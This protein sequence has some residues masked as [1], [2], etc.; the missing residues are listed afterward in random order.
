[1]WTSARVRCASASAWI[2]ELTR[3]TWH[4]AERLPHR[5][6][7]N[8]KRRKS[9]PFVAYDR[10]CRR[11]VRLSCALVVLQQTG[12]NSTQTLLIVNTREQNV[13]RQRG[14]STHVQP[15]IK[16]LNY[17][18]SIASSIWTFDC[19]WDLAAWG[20][21]GNRFK[22]HCSTR[23]PRAR[24]STP[25]RTTRRRSTATV[26]T[27]TQWQSKL[28]PQPHRSA[29]HRTD[30]RRRPFSYRKH[31][32]VPEHEHRRVPQ[33]VLRLLHIFFCASSYRFKSMSFFT[34]FT[35]EQ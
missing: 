15:L 16:P 10:R 2:V 29:A 25:R 35:S 21:S 33:R 4:V 12:S 32:I 18:S 13:E 3:F 9:V 30:G 26:S 23:L 31:Q 24:R 22:T 28:H 7:D 34:L 14:P 6:F 11:Q 17:T 8:N 5:R 1:M 27:S 19:V 20:H